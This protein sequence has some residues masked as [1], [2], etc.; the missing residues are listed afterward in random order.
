MLFNCKKI[1]MIGMDFAYYLTLLLSPPN[2]DRLKKFT[3]EEDLKLFYT[4][5]YNP[6]LKK[7]FYTDHVYAWYKKVHDGNDFKLKIKNIQ[8][9]RRRHLI[10]SKIG[11]TSLIKFCK[12]K[13]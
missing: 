6:N 2:T 10:W 13:S 3:K 9:Y 7:Y 1:A 4:K 8:L 12:I 11:W 5:I